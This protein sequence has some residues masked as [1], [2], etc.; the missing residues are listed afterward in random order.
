M[1]TLLN[2]TNFKVISR[3]IGLTCFDYDVIVVFVIW[4]MSEHSSNLTEWYKYGSLKSSIFNSMIR[5][6]N[7]KL[8]NC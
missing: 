8:E 4:I 1:A 2:F 6:G 5:C 7:L 3:T